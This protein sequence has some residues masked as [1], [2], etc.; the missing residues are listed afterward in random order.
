MAFYNRQVKFP[1]KPQVTFNKIK[2]EYTTKVKCLGMHIT[3]SLKWNLQIQILAN[4]LI[5]VSFM[6]KSLKGIL[7]PYMIR[8]IYF[9][10]F[11][12]L[13]RFGIL[14]WGGIGSDLSKRIFRIQKRVIR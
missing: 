3:K 7:S 13:L 1:I 10:K 12:A 6:I 2:L 5:K 9:T 8:T 4:K 11:Q 14:F